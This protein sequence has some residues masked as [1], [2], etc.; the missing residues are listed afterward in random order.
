MAKFFLKTG[1]V[2]ATLL[3]VFCVSGCG[4]LN[5][6][7]QLGEQVKTPLQQAQDFVSSLDSKAAEV[8]KKADEYIE[9]LGKS[10][11]VAAKLKFDEIIKTLDEG[12]NIEVPDELKDEGE[13]YKNACNNL[14]DALNSLND[15]ANGS[16][17]DA[18]LASKLAEA[19]S[20]YDEAAKALEEADKSLNEK[21]NEL[22]TKK[23]S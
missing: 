19:Q 10:D 9:A 1:A 18:D 17:T 8:S 3:V 20:K 16:L 22:N 12:A 23:A 2:L 15:V 11:S 21:M 5:P 7:N 6:M 13:K 14:K 4:S